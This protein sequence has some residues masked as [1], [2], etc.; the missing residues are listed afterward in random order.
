[1]IDKSVLKGQKDN[2]NKF[3]NNFQSHSLYTSRKRDK[4]EERKERMERRIREKINLLLQASLGSYR[5]RLR[6]YH[7]PCVSYQSDLR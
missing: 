7:D 1:M 5:K 6:A 2:T 3:S 4:I